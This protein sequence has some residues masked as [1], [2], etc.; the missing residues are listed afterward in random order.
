ML[1]KPAVLAMPSE[2]PDEDSVG[3]DAVDFKYDAF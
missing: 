2:I 1:L 3:G